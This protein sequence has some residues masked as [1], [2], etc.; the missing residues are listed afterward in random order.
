VA[1]RKEN[2]MK[3]EKERRT[4]G[5]WMA[6]SIH[7]EE[8]RK[9]MNIT[10]RLRDPLGINLAAIYEATYRPTLRVTREMTP[11]RAALSMM[12][13]SPVV[14]VQPNQRG[15][16]RKLGGRRWCQAMVTT[17]MVDVCIDRGM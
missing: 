11:R 12:T 2:G 17:A 3:T 8:G 4:Q 5:G 7:H 1:Y 6:G 9:N 13:A 14:A 10:Y 16:V 15:T